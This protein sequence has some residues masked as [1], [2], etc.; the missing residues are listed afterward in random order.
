M[1]PFMALFGLALMLFAL[2]GRAIG[3]PIS[4]IVSGVLFIGGLVVMCVGTGVTLMAFYRRTSA[5]VAFVRTGSGGSR[6]VLDGGIRVYP[7][8]HRVLEINLRTMKLG[9]NPR[10]QNALITH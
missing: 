3:L 5:D 2:L 10:G 6:V 7:W 4:L 8:L 9:V 1:G